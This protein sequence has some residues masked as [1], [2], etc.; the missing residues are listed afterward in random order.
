MIPPV[1]ERR[2]RDC[3]DDLEPCMF[4]TAG[5][6]CMLPAVQYYKPMNERYYDRFKTPC[7][8]HMTI[9]EYAELIESGSV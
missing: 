8:Y 3:N 7:E 5:E 9:H 1:E 2:T 6:E 4:F